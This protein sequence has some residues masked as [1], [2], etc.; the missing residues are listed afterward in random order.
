[1]ETISVEI[2]RRTVLEFLSR[3]CDRRSAGKA[4]SR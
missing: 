4:V 3:F 2:K 1:M